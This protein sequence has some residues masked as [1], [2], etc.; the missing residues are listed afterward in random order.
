MERRDMRG[1]MAPGQREMKVIDVEV[2]KIKA[3]GIAE[4]LLQHQTM[5]G[6]C[7]NTLRVETQGALARGDEL[8][9]GDRITAGK[10]GDFMALLD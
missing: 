9:V 1:A 4:D 3:S 7:I 2:D 5:V 6:E 8:G 10:Q